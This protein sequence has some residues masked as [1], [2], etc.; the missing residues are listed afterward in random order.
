MRKRERFQILTL[1]PPPLALILRLFQLRGLGSI[2]LGYFWYFFIRI[3]G[4]QELL[5]ELEKIPVMPRYEP[6]DFAK[7]CKMNGRSQDLAVW[8]FA[9]KQ[10][11]SFTFC[12]HFFSFGRKLVF[13]NTKNLFLEFGFFFMLCPFW[14]HLSQKLPIFFIC[15]FGSK[16]PPKR[17]KITK[18]KN[19][20]EQ[21]LFVSLNASFLQKQRNMDN[22]KMS[23][24]G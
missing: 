8:K 4:I 20:K 18:L 5:I 7:F 10:W 21:V 16:W 3:I 11:S 19:P 13:W 17:P 15:Q 24:I 23:S 12:L 9:C 22:M 6:T 1:D 2:C 14:G